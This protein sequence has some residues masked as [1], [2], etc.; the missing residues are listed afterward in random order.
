MN[1]QNVGRHIP[2][3]GSLDNY[4][5]NFT[6]YEDFN[7]SQY[8][9]SNYGSA[10]HVSIFG[11][12]SSATSMKMPSNNL[13]YN[14]EQLQ[15]TYSNNPSVQS[16]QML[17][18]YPT[19]YQASYYPQHPQHLQ[20]LQHP[21]HPQHPQHLLPPQQL[22]Q[23]LSQQLSQYPVHQ[24][25]NPPTAT[26]PQYP[27]QFSNQT[28]QHNQPNV[29]QRTNIRDMPEFANGDNYYNCPTCKQLAVRVYDK[30]KICRESGKDKIEV[31]NPANKSNPLIGKE[32]QAAINIKFGSSFGIS[33]CIA[34]GATSFIF[35]RPAEKMAYLENLAISG[36]D[37]DELLNKCKDYRK[38]RKELESKQ[39]GIIT[40][41]EAEVKEH[42]FPTK[43]E[44][45]LTGKYSDKKINNQRTIQSNNKKIMVTY[46]RKLQKLIIKQNNAQLNQQKYNQ[47][48]NQSQL[49]KERM[50][51]LI[52]QRNTIK[53]S[54]IQELKNIITQIHNINEVKKLEN[55]LAETILQ[56]HDI[57]EY[58]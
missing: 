55:E 48:N 40:M 37:T 56:Y 11:N 18:Q 7:F 4:N 2:S 39:S 49:L 9:P 33:S 14:T 16:Q 15:P 57:E 27:N 50:N 28:N 47:L 24:P 29:T 51:K 53:L 20:H 36:Y 46:S 38:I 5:Q 10:G 26:M 43:I 6:G 8:A 19:S 44:W 41:L 52:T 1:N 23:Q 31:F 35:M 42:P 30:W 45:P 32:A 17:G 25:N 34:D 21:Q 13:M 22:P 12:E 54:D 58:Q 3:M